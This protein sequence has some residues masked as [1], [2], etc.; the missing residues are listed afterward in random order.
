MEEEYAMFK[1]I[2]DLDQFREALKDNWVDNN[3]VLLYTDNIREKEISKLVMRAIDKHFAANEIMG[4]IDFLAT[5]HY[6]CVSD[7]DIYTGA[8][9][10]YAKYDK[11]SFIRTQVSMGRLIDD[12]KELWAIIESVMNP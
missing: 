12:T 7:Y 3:T 6:A 5:E 11:N 10:H 2:I 9:T 8:S 4:L 1:V